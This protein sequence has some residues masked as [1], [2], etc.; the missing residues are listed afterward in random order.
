MSFL[1]HQGWLDV[2][3]VFQELVHPVKQFFNWVEGFVTGLVK[4]TT[5]HT[6][7]KVTSLMTS[8]WY[9]GWVMTSY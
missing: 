8:Q 4:K 5:C 7:G 9:H 3:C 6:S 1:V 2:C